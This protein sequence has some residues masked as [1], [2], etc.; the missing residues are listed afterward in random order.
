[1]RIWLGG[2]G[3][4]QQLR[5]LERRVK[6][7]KFRRMPRCILQRTVAIGKLG[8]CLYFFLSV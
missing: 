4:G 7:I 1:M 3:I 6:Q 2:G 5:P 8:L